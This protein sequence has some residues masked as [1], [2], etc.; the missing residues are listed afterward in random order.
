MPES[1]VHELLAAVEQLPPDACG[2]WVV[3]LGEVGVG[4]V[5]V[6]RNRVCW[7]AHADLS[8]R[9]RQLLREHLARTDTRKTDAMRRALE[10]HTIE[11]LLALPQ[12][13]GEHVIWVD[14]QN[15]GYQPRFTFAPSELLVG[16]NAFLYESEALGAE[17]ALSSLDLE[18][19]A[20]S[21]VPADGG[22]LVPVR[23]SGPFLQVAALDELGAWADAAFG[24]TR[25]FS[26]DVVRRAA[27]AATGDVCVAWQTSRLHTH[28]A[29]LPRGPTLE[30]L[31]SQVE[32]RRFPA[33]ISRRA[34]CAAQSNP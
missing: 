17:L 3:M 22:G 11:S 15:N 13:V 10:R 34:F 4:S 2:A 1:L 33:V 24:A 14:H 18:T 26:H 6:E 21:F 8:K 12:D 16:V 23:T 9:L 31:I 28:A 5:F 27:E 25:G 7:A 32:G 29:L 19:P 20:A 30:R